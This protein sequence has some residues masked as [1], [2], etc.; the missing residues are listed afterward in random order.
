MGSEVHKDNDCR[1][2]AE[3]GHRP[4]GHSR[5]LSGLVGGLPGISVALGALGQHPL[6]AFLA[7]S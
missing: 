2:E 4:W 7:G 5:P 1:G 6:F 3:G